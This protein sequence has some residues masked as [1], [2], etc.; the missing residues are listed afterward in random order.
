MEKQEEIKKYVEESDA[1]GV[2]PPPVTRSPTGPGSRLT[3][4]PATPEDDF[5]F[6]II[7]KALAKRKQKRKNK[8]PLVARPCKED[9]RRNKVKGG[10]Q[11]QI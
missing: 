6:I 5:F 10:V 3:H 2:P 1:L 4:N 7:K 9:S 8:I 11:G